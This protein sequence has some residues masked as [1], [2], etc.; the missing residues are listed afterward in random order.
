MI[1]DESFRIELGFCE[2]T[3]LRLAKLK[4]KMDGI[5]IGFKSANVCE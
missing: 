4:I 3:H 1:I 5:E 2:N